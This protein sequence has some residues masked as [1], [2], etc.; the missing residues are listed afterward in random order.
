MDPETQPDAGGEQPPVA[1]D[2]Y[3]DA[4]A[5]RIWDEFE[6]AD[7][8]QQAPSDT[9]S[10]DD[11]AGTENDPDDQAAAAAGDTPAAG[12]GEDNADQPDIW[13]NATPE[14]R[15]EFER[16]QRENATLTRENQGRAEQLRRRIVENDRQREELE[17]LRAGG[18][19]QPAQNTTSDDP[20]SAPAEGAEDK[21]ERW[22]K[23][24][25]EYP[26]I[27]GPMADVRAENESLRRQLGSV[28][29]TLK[30]LSENERTRL[31]GNQIEA[32]SERHP[33]WQEVTDSDHFNS[34][35]DMQPDLVRQLVAINGEAIVDADSGARALDLYKADYP[36]RF[37]TSQEPSP[38]PA[39]G[40]DAG[41]PTQTQQ[42][43]LST[44]RR[45]QL[46]AAASPRSSGP[47]AA[48]DNGPGEEASE[49]EWWDWWERQ[50]Q[51]KAAQ[52]R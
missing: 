41:G 40:A 42:P 33:D 24:Q 46:A 35:L 19:Q 30:G 44:R 25:Q 26:E 37:A 15:A 18:E 16:L 10:G 12:A 49:E 50:E 23:F 39:P 45:T 20:A 43:N 5:Q 21:A 14:Q 2:V 8:G 29:A 22:Q 3:D 38:E 17:A 4:E 48:V 7:S 47:S 9:P 52:S 1:G 27:A 31:V 36:D 28:T 13:A 6:A 51:R 34:W 11:P 32:L